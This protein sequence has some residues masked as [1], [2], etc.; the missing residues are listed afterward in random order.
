MT[1]KCLEIKKTLA[2]KS[3]RPRRQCRYK[4]SSAGH[5]QSAGEADKTKG[6]ETEQKDNAKLSDNEN[7]MKS[8][9]AGQNV[10]SLLASMLQ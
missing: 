8:W 2:N 1:M 5:F 6:G 4:S 7:V 9:N 3:S 10:Q